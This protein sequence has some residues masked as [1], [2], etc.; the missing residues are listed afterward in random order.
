MYTYGKT[1]KMS[2][3]EAVEA[4]KTALKEQGFGVL[5]EIDAQAVLKSKTG[6]DIGAYVILGGCHAQTALRALTADPGIGTLLPCNVVVYERE[7]SVTVAAIDA[8]AM[9]SV[10]GNPQVAPLAQEVN[11]RLRAA[12]DSLG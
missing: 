4:A 9:L 8:E 12:V 3:A 2:F 5:C 11:G 7:G 6:Q 1:V 10:V